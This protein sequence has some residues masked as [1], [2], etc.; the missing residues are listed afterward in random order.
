MDSIQPLKDKSLFWHNIWVDMGRP[1]EGIVAHIRRSTRASYHRAI[2]QALKDGNNI[3]KNKLADSIL[4]NNSRDFWKEIKKFKRRRRNFPTVVDNLNQPDEIVSVF[5]NS[6]KSLFSSV[7]PSTENMTKLR[8]DIDNQLN[9]LSPHDLFVVKWDDVSNAV[10]R[11]KLGKHEGDGALSSDFIIQAPGALYVHFALL[12]SAM[13]NHGLV[14]HS[15]CSST[16]IPIPK[17]SQSGCNSNN[18]RGIALSSILGKV[19]D[20]ILLERLSSKLDTS[21]LQFGFKRGHST[22][23]CTMVLKETVAYYTSHESSVH[24]VMLDATKAFDR[25]DYYKLF[26]K[27]INRNISPVVIRFLLNLYT[28][29]VSRVRWN[30]VFSLYFP[31]HNGVRQGAI[32]SPILFCLYIDELLVKLKSSKVG[33]YI[34]NVFVG[35]LCYAD[36]LSLLAPSADA[37]RKMLQICEE[38]AAEHGI[39]FNATKSKYIAFNAHHNAFEDSNPLFYLNDKLIERV[40]CWPHLGNILADNQS[41]SICINKRRDQM[42]GQI[43]DVL[44]T[45]GKLDCITKV[46]LLYKYCNSLYGSV[47][48][49]LS[50]PDILRICSAWRTALIRCWRLPFNTHNKLVMALSSKVSLLDELRMRLIKFHFNCLNSTNDIVKF[51]CL[52]STSESRAL[53]PHGRNLLH[54]SSHYGF[55]FRSF[56]C[57]DGM[58]SIIHTIQVRSNCAVDV[59]SNLG[60]LCEL[61]SLRDNLSV[62]KPSYAAFSKAEIETL[63]DYLCTA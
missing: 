18:Y 40:N 43:N 50:N 58:S 12:I 45:F 26:A 9:S 29:Q 38:F 20:L 10:H 14:S 46:E 30:D 23:M 15:T 6:Y 5:A 51:V 13:I 54:T 22:N 7:T 31:I 49:N 33:C 37:M 8:S 57:S 28:N 27:L 53:S 4:R 25:V 59:D 17:G 44:S 24:C 34:G 3:V 42:I 32:S 52:N 16:I 55:S 60:L 61:I 11:L 19:I 56:N 36:D 63:I 39:M 21:H 47:L 48:W 2:R 1:H 62:F 35:A 41:D